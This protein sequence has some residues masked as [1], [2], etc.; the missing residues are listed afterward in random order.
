MRGSPVWARRAPRTT[1]RAF[2]GRRR[3]PVRPLLRKADRTSGIAT[4]NGVGDNLL[5]VRSQEA[6]KNADGHVLVFLRMC[7]L[8]CAPA[9]E[10]GRLLRLLLLRVGE[11]PAE[12]SRRDHVEERVMEQKVKPFP[13]L[14]PLP[15][16]H[17]PELKENFEFS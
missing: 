12:A 5:E 1:G 4:D 9:P 3:L 14:A 2:A 16:G 13:R 11:V 6:G 7:G 8:R 10:G 15:V 17:A